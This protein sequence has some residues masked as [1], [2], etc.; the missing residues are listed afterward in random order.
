MRVADYAS[1]T[2][3]AEP[4]ATGKTRAVGPDLFR[5]LALHFIVERP[6]LKLRD[7]VLARRAA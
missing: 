3:A 1:A 7:R 4:V 5:A 2:A 6:F